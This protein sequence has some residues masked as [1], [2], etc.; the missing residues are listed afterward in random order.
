MGDSASERPLD[1]GL[2]YVVATLR[3]GLIVELKGCRDRGAALAYV[4]ETG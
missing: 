4:S 2:A 1:D 3:D